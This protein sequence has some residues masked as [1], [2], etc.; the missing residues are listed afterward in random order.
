MFKTENVAKQMI[1]FN[2]CPAEPGDTLPFLH[3]VDPDQLDSEEAN[4]LICTIC[5]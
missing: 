1:M 5:H 3:S 4:I 2:P